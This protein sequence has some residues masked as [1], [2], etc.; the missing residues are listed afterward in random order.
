M[1]FTITTCTHHHRNKVKLLSMRSAITLLP[2]VSPPPGYGG[3]G[4]GERGVPSQGVSSRAAIERAFVRHV[5]NLVR[6]GFDTTKLSLI[7]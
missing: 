6:Y 1:A 3:R 7:I 5:R 2:Q 4:D